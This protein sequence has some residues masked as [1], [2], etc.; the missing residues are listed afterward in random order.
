MQS[1]SETA[2]KASPAGSVLAEALRLDWQPPQATSGLLRAFCAVVP[3]RERSGELAD[4]LDWCAKPGGLS[5]RLYT[6]GAGSGKTRL[7][8]EACTAL[9]R[10]GW[11]AGFF[12][13]PLPDGPDSRWLE[14]LTPDRPLLIVIDDASERTQAIFALAAPLAAGAATGSRPRRRCACRR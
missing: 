2:T 9:Q 1:G 12:A 6:G 8:I 4:L 10:A 5:V 7:L 11:R 13:P 3:F 14:A